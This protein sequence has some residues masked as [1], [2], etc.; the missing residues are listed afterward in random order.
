MVAISKVELQLSVCRHSLIRQFLALCASLG[1]S[2]SARL[3]VEFAIVLH[4][5]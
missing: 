1:I 2:W 4:V 3:R 5:V